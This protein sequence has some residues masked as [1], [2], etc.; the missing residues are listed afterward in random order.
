MGIGKA[1]GPFLRSPRD[2]WPARRFTEKQKVGIPRETDEDT[3]LVVERFGSFQLDNVGRLKQL[4]QSERST[5]D[6]GG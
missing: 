1:G 2:G 5:K 4:E 3:V 6:D